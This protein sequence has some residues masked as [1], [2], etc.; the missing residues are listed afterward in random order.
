MQ[1]IFNFMSPNF[2][3]EF[4]LV[5]LAAEKANIWMMRHDDVEITKMEKSSLRSKQDRIIESVRSAR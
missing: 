4:L 3:S 2:V 5:R 1:V